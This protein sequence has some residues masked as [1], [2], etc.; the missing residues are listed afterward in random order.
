MIIDG[1]PIKEVDSSNIQGYG[2]DE[3]GKRLAVK[4][5]QKNT[6]IY[7]E[8][9]LEVFT[10]LEDAESKGKAFYKHVRD[11]F[12]FERIKAGDARIQG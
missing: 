5:T 1:I 3:E 8:V 7:F 12:R 10:L 11:N 9:P 4:F 6:Y 2:Y